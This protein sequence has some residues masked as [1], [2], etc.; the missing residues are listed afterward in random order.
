[1]NLKSHTIPRF[2]KLV[3]IDFPMYGNIFTQFMEN[4]WEYPYLCHSR[5]LRDLVCV[6]GCIFNMFWLRESCRKSQTCHKEE[7]PQKNSW[8]NW[9]LLMFMSPCYFT[10]SARRGCSSEIKEKRNGREKVTFN[11]DINVNVNVIAQ[12]TNQ[13]WINVETTWSST[14]MN[15]ISTLIFG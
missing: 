5:I 2:G 14:F 13:G 3:S 9:Y 1:M 6:K 11:K 12:Q 7:K 10:Y 15:F 8:V 4:K